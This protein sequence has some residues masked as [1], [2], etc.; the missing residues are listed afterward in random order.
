MRVALIL[1][2]AA[3][4]LPALAG[5]AASGNWPQFRGPGATGT[6]PGAKPPTEWNLEDGTNVLWRTP[7]PGLGH[8]APVVWGDRIYLT[9]AV[10]VEGEDELKVGLY[11][12]IKPVNC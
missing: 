1:L 5:E 2:A 3:A 8:S 10:R 11:G 4:L 9:S 12:D 6:A 7:I